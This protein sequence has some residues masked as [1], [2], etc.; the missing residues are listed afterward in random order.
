MA[1]LGSVLALLGLI[2]TG[3]A[4]RKKP[5]PAIQSTLSFIL[6]CATGLGCA[7]PKTERMIGC[8]I[9]VLRHQYTGITAEL[10]WGI[11]IKIGFGS[12]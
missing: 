8:T 7:L 6:M 10:G 12:C 4:A 9:L 1:C 11:Q 3:T 2:S 5:A